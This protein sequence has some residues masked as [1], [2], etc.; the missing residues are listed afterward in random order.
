MTSTN[1]PTSRGLEICMARNPQRR[2]ISARS[3]DRRSASGERCATAGRP[4]DIGGPRR[5]P[6]RRGPLAGRTRSPGPSGGSASTVAVA[7]P[8]RPEPPGAR[9]WDGSANARGLGRKHGRENDKDQQHRERDHRRST[10]GGGQERTVLSHGCETPGQPMLFQGLTGNFS[11][12][13]ARESRRT[14]RAAGTRL[15]CW[16]TRRR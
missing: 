8:D 6:A 13:A 5:A 9:R 7:S 10:G 1:G 3:Q 15:G 16:R 11:Y 4:P 14:R 12:C 2:W